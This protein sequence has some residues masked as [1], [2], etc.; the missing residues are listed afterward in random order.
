MAQEAVTNALRPA[1]DARLVRVSVGDLGADVRVQVVD[2]GRRAPLG[3]WRPGYGLVGMAERVALLGGTF[4]AG[5]AG[6]QGWIVEA[7]VPRAGA[8]S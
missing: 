2:D 5:P 6:E 3:P 8:R 7:T 4:E 1:R